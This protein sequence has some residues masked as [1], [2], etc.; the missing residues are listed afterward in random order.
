MNLKWEIAKNLYKMSSELE[1]AKARAAEAE[2]NMVKAAEFGNQLLVQLRDSEN[3][4][5]MLEQEK[6]SLKRSLEIKE[7]SEL[8]MQDEINDLNKKAVILEGSAKHTKELQRTLDLLNAE[9]AKKEEEHTAA[10]EA[11]KLEA[12]ERLAASVPLPGSPGNTSMM[13]PEALAE[14]R[15]EVELLRD[16]VV[17][18]KEE[19]GRIK[20]EFEEMEF[21]THSLRL[22]I[23]ELQKSISEKDDELVSY[24]SAMQEAQEEMKMMSLETDDDDLQIDVAPKGNSLFSEVEDR[25]H[26]A[27]EKLKKCQAK[28]EGAKVMLEK[29]NSEMSKLRMQ[30]IH[31]RN[32]A[33]NASSGACEVQQLERLQ[34]QL[35]RERNQNKILASKLSAMPHAPQVA[36]G[37]AS[38]ESTMVAELMRQTLVDSEKI[39]ELSK[40]AGTLERQL[41]QLKSEN[42]ILK[43]RLVEKNQAIKRNSSS[44]LEQAAQP[45][46]MEFVVED[47]VFEK[48]AS[49]PK[50]GP[51]LEPLKE[52]TSNVNSSITAAEIKKPTKKS[53]AFA[54]DGE[55]EDVEN[56]ESKDKKKIP[57][58]Q[59]E[60]KIVD[61]EEEA[62]KFNE[63]CKQQ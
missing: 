42:A 36:S 58:I 15:D 47:I 4:R 16:Q 59:K 7:A 12:Y 30:N 29:R 26:I 13:D 11:L 56:E 33:S 34:E 63:Q 50:T 3:L 23:S 48:K 9:M 40:H 51:A 55:T 8:A 37:A 14:L 44:T 52:T 17:H 49:T 38:E 31:L 21:S 20:A 53:V 32:M 43:M 10:I 60:R 54:D 5:A 62:A 1:A 19:N 41:S 24:R 57:R 6:H 35:H 25:R 39:E 27:E 22:Q 18:Y 45:K 61:A 46:G 28:Y 2:A